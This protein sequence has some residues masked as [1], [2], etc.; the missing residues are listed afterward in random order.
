MVRDGARDK[1]RRL[2]GYLS[3][4]TLALATPDETPFD[5]IVFWKTSGIAVSLDETTSVRD[6]PG[7]AGANLLSVIEKGIND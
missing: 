5:A 2:I 6:G 7:R 4:E 3:E 1:L